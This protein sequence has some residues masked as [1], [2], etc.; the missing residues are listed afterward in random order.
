MSKC[1][2]FCW[3]LIETNLEESCDSTCKYETIEE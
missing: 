3:K 1:V 2:D